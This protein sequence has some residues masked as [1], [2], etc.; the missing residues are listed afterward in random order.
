MHIFISVKQ[1]LIDLT[2]KKCLSPKYFG[3][4]KYLQSDRLSIRCLSAPDLRVFL[5]NKMFILQTFPK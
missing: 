1:F 3:K 4:T 5:L 2:E